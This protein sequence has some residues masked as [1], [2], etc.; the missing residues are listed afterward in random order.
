MRVANVLICLLLVFTIAAIGNTVHAQDEQQESI[1]L[2]GEENVGIT[3][4]SPLYGLSVALDRIRLALTFNKEK[5]AE[6]GLKIAEKH[7]MKAKVLAMKGK[8]KGLDKAT[9]NYA[10]FLEIARKQLE[11]AKM[12]NETERAEKIQALITQLEMH[13][14]EVGDAEELLAASNIPDEQKERI[15]QKLEEMRQRAE[16]HR[17]MVEAKREQIKTILKQKYNLTDEE[18]EELMEKVKERAI[19]KN[20]AFRA[21]LEIEKANR[22][23]A[24]MEKRII[25]LSENTNFSKERLDEAENMLDMARELYQQAVEAYTSKSYF[26]AWELAKESQRIARLSIAQPS[27][28]ALNRFLE[29]RAIREKFC[30]P[31]EAIETVSRFVPGERCRIRSFIE[32]AYVITCQTPTGLRTFMVRAS[33]CEA[34]TAAQ[35]REMIREQV[36]ERAREGMGVLEE[37]QKLLEKLR[38]RVRERLREERENLTGNV[39]ETCVDMCGDGV[40]QEVVCEAIGCPCPET[41]K[42][43]PQDCGGK[44]EIAKTMEEIQMPKTPAGEGAGE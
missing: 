24:F 5:K 15:I 6:L 37:E 4:D 19:H 8:A 11:E 30:A 22:T 14:E 27:P 17:K 18:A 33:D 1:L 41:P 9:A 44:E 23:I 25:W 35:V 26:R 10:R 12:R 34:R 29:R 13:E 16:E 39:N 40:C 7:L 38:E 43:C 36:R 42:T 2:P 21:N 31:N 20:I 3:P 32:N 28:V